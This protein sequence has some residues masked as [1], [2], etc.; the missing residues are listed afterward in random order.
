MEQTRATEQESVDGVA[1]EKPEP[2]GAEGEV[3]VKEPAAATARR[4]LIKAFTV[5]AI[6]AIVGLGSGGNQ[7]AI[8]AFAGCLAAAIYTIGYVR[9][10]VFR[11]FEESTFD[12]HVTRY[13]ALR[14]GAVIGTGV[15]LFV[16]LGKPATQAYLLALAACWLILVA[17][18]APR[19]LKQ[20]RARGIIG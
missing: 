5:G 18:E 13:A 6:A 20:L 2:E 12:P 9:S 7:A 8:G 11:K 19:A 10:H 4:V 14:L 1:I 17:T 3:A 16:T 15:A